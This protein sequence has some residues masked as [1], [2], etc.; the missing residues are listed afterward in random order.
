LCPVRAPV[1]RPP[2][3]AR[4]DRHRHH[5]TRDI[6][7]VA[8]VAGARVRRA[9]D[10][11]R[12]DLAE[13]WPGQT[14]R[15]R[16]LRPGGGLVRSDRSWGRAVHRHR[17]L[18]QDRH[19]PF[20]QD[21]VLPNWGFFG[22]FLTVA[23]LVAGLGLLFGVLTR[24]AAL[25]SLLLIT[26]IWLMYIDT[27]PVPVALPGRPVPAAAARDRARRADRR[28]GRPPR[29]P[30]RRALA[31]LIG[32]RA[33]RVIGW[34]SRSSDRRGLGRIGDHDRSGRVDMSGHGIP[35][36]LRVGR[37]TIVCPDAV[38]PDAMPNPTN[39]TVPPVRPA[40]Q[41][42]G[43]ARST[44]RVRPPPRTPIPCRGFGSPDPAD[45]PVAVYPP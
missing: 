19:R 9:A 21:V 24:A 31:V 42:P 27:T 33:E 2:G 35:P 25:G 10:L 16:R 22:A 6:H 17:S 23:E 11:L 39:R 40:G 36:P 32:P 15:G 8:P 1:D 26:P 44:H 20:Y 41:S 18:G 29:R 43:Q 34:T 13:Q 12:A 38:C 4:D 30:V 3:G 45:N 14:V 37:P 5:P 7:R 28:L